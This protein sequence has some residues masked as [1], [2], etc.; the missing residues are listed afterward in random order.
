MEDWRNDAMHKHTSFLIG[1][2]TL[3][4]DARLAGARLLLISP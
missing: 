3:A 2:E 4:L 1:L